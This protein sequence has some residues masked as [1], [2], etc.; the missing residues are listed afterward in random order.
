MSN[1][2]S[3]ST[4]KALFKLKKNKKNCHVKCEV[5]SCPIIQ[6]NDAKNINTNKHLQHILIQ[7]SS[8]L[9]GSVQTKCCLVLFV[10]YIQW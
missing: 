5:T 10:G 8:N 9:E 2:T 1:T 7:F 6:K 4:F 3:H